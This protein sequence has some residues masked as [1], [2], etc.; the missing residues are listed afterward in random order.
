VRSRDDAEGWREIEPSEIPGESAGHFV[1][2]HSIGTTDAPQSAAAFTAAEQR[3]ARLQFIT[4]D[5]RLAGAARKEDFAM[6][7][8]AIA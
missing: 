4:L 5:E 6:V 8:L 1:W 3:L 7:Q 2:V